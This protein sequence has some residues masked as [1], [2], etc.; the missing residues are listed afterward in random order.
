M[1]DKHWEMLGDLLTRIM[2]DPQFATWQDRRD[3]LMS[4]LDDDAKSAL[5]EIAGWFAE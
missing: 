1:N 2:R 4:K 3:N 5:E